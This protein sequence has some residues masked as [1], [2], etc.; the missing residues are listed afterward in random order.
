MTRSR[1]CA[2]FAR[3]IIFCAIIFVLRTFVQ[4]CSPLF[5][6]LKLRPRGRE[7]FV[8]LM[9]NWIFYSCKKKYRRGQPNNGC[10]HPEMGVATYYSVIRFFHLSDN[11]LLLL[12]P[13]L[14][15][16]TVLKKGAVFSLPRKFCCWLL[17][18]LAIPEAKRG[19][20]IIVRPIIIE[21]WYTKR[22]RQT[23]DSE[24]QRWKKPQQTIY[25]QIPLAS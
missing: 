21:Y 5:V 22:L 25:Q 4:S 23:S 11:L 1:E 2:R 13:Q 24:R 18:I 14:F 17:L 12:G 8:R 15:G 6:S 20:V 7:W 16:S 10:D 3:S 9:I 19:R